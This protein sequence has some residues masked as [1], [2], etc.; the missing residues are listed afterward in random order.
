MSPGCS[1]VAAC[2]SQKTAGAQFIS[3]LSYNNISRRRWDTFFT[4]R[5]PPFKGLFS[6]KENDLHF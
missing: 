2:A 3:L 6:A 4:E 5:T 1:L